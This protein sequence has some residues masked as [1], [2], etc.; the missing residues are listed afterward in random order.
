MR[1]SEG[2]RHM[3]QQRWLAAG[4]ALVVCLAAGAWRPARGQAPGVRVATDAGAAAGSGV[5]AG[6]P[7]ATP[8]AA[9][10]EIDRGAAGLWQMLRKLHTRASMLMVV[11]HPDDEDG[12]M[13]AYESRGQGARVSLM[14]LNRGEGGQNVMSDDYWD[15][16]GLVRTEELLAADRYYGVQQFWSSVVD[17]GFSK[18]LEETMAQWGHDRVLADVVRVVRMTRPLV[19]TSVFVGGPTDGHGHHAA[20][21]QM[22]QEVF[23]AAGDPNVFP[24]QIRAGLRPWSPLKMYARV[25]SFSVSDKGIY[26]SATGKYFPVRFYDFIAKKWSDG[27]PAVNLEVTEGNYDPALGATYLQTAR[28]GWSLQK[29]QNGGG[30]IPFA[31]PAAIPYHRYGSLGAAKDKE[32]SFFEGVDVSLAGIAELAP[33]ADNGF[34]RDALGRIN[35]QVERAMSEFSVEHP[36]KIAPALAEGLTETNALAAQVSGSGLSEQSKYDVLHELAAKQAQFQQAIVEA[37]GVSLEATV[38]PKRE[39]GRGN[40][41]GGTGPTETFAYAIPGQQFAV[42]AHIDNPG[43]SAVALE[44]AWVEGPA[45]ESWTIAPEQPVPASVAAGQAIDA[46][47]NVQVPDNAAPTRPYFTRPNDEQPFYDIIDERYRNLSLD[48]VSA[49]GVGR[50]SGTK[51]WR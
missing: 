35:T 50:L 26:D 31:G 21:G 13:L 20:A 4:A 39:S 51:G 8:N 38:A 43:A 48:P 42:K 9:P 14:T 34:L 46:R 30:T 41:L 32:Q 1:E 49:D 10:L 29:S 6:A 2:R 11:A 45:G 12:G 36:E 23:Q 37:L 44:R 24:E 7:E 28:Q 15:A 33:G 25:P 40:F 19:V 47:F 16:L 5:P 22:A 27:A 3:T 18:T 17:F